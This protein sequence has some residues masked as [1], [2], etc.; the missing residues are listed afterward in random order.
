MNLRTGAY[1]R[2]IARW[3]WTHAGGLV[4]VFLGRQVPEGAANV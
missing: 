2:A 3:T 4:G 1:S